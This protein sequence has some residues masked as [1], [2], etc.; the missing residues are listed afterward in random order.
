MKYSPHCNEGIAQTSHA[1]KV[2]ELPRTWNTLL[3]LI[4]SP[5]TRFEMVDHAARPELRDWRRLVIQH[6]CVSAGEERG[7]CVS[8]KKLVHI[9]T[10]L[11]YK[12]A[13][14]R[15]NSPT[16][17]RGHLFCVKAGNSCRLSLCQHLATLKPSQLS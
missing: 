13:T 5:R 2:M 6:V 3:T 16:H 8:K 1:M 14:N 12:S 15:R 10:T 9:K 7:A 11:S 4:A 17:K